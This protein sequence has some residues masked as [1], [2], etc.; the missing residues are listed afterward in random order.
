MAFHRKSEVIFSEIKSFCMHDCR[1][2]AATHMAS[3]RI[4]GE[5]LSR[6]LNHAKKGVT[7]RHYIKHSYDDEK[8]E[9]AKRNYYERTS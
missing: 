7:E 3:L 1:R 8:R 2:T 6:I 5:T 4:S 9:Q